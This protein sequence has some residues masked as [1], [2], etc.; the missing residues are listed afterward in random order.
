MAQIKK[1]GKLSSMSSRQKITA[2]VLVVVLIFVG[3]ELID[4]FGGGKSETPVATTPTPAAQ[5]Q[6]GQMTVNGPT[7]APPA[8]PSPQNPAMAAAQGPSEQPLLRETTVSVDSQILELQ[9]K[10]EQIYVDQINQLQMLK[11]QRE[12]AETNQAIASARL[13]TVTA[14]KNVSDLLTR[15]STPPTS[16]TQ[17]YLASTSTGEM[18]IPLPQTGQIPPAPIEVPY[19]VISVSMQLGRWNAVVGYQGKM[20]NVSIGDVLPLDG[21][22]V[23]S[24]SKNG[25]MLVKNGKRRRVGILSSL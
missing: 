22:V 13:A 7:G 12:I 25:V 21:S 14:E 18:A 23:V 6:P 15:P 20:F 24:I 1:L 5:K 8:R 9:K 16:Q 11:L 17:A 4:L 2:I 19:V 10:S 3:W